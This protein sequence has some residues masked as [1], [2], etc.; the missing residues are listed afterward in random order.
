MQ[1]LECL[2]KFHD[3]QKTQISVQADPFLVLASCLA[4]QPKHFCCTPECRWRKQ[5]ATRTL[6]ICFMQSCLLFGSK[7]HHAPQPASDR[8]KTCSSSPRSFGNAQRYMT[9]ARSAYLDGSDLGCSVQSGMPCLSGDSSV[10]L[11]LLV[12][13]G[14]L[15]LPV[16][17]AKLLLV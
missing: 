5:H 15:H 7:V 9:L 3:M 1:E 16:R 8:L 17:R 14:H 2:R 12:V 11:S 6:E 10:S 4:P 13:K